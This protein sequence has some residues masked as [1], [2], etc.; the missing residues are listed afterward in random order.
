MEIEKPAASCRP[1]LEYNEKKVLAGVAELVGYANMESPSMEEV[2]NLFDRREKTRYFISEKGFHASVNPSPEEG[3]TEE[4]VLD[5]IAGMMERLGYGEQ[6]YLVYRHYDIERVHYHVVSSRVDADGRKINNHYE[7]RRTLAYMRE[8][9]PR[10]GFSVVEKGYRVEEKA[11]LKRD[12]G[13]TRVRRFDPRRGV[14][15]Q[16]REICSAA[17]TYDFH[18]AGQFACILEDLGVEATVRRADGE[19]SLMELRGL[20][21]D[22]VPV[23]D[24]VSEEALGLP[25]GTQVEEASRDSG[26]THGVRSRERERVKGLSEFAFGISHSEDHFR[27]ILRNKGIEVHLSRSRD[28]GRVFG[29][30]YVDHVTRTVFKASELRTGVTPAA[31]EEALE[32]GRWRVERRP[33]RPSRAQHI[34]VSRASA[35]RDA[36]RLRDLHVGAVARILTPMGQ[37]V[38]DSQRGQRE[39]RDNQK[40]RRQAGGFR[41]SFREKIS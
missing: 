26:K 32:S 10:Y 36:V 13:R 31:M 23:T 5:F 1:A 34:R 25:L 41:E 15:E 16:L 24:T 38:G 35:Y 39:E 20:G 40:D 27:N 14:G 6:P 17:L 33:E 12:G 11:D 3:M 9:A 19:R 8:V 18:G 30:T 7:H 21:R 2:F 37:P 22:G 29:I 4:E 28:T